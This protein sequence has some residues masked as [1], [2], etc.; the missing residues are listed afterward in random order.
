[1]FSDLGEQ[2]LGAAAQEASVDEQYLGWSRMCRFYGGAAQIVVLYQVNSLLLAV[3]RRGTLKLRFAQRAR[4][5]Q[6][7]DRPRRVL[8]GP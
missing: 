3:H 4:L 6:S 1:M 2:Q 5:S 7:G 8:I